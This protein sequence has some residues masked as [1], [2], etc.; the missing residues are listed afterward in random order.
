MTLMVLTFV[1]NKE[2]DLNVCRTES[3]SSVAR[4]LH[5]RL[6]ASL[7]QPYMHV[8]YNHNATVVTIICRI[9]AERMDQMIHISVK[10]D[11]DIF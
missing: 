8:Y 5:P 7:L 3:K 10:S 1:A 6:S 2:L 11:L 4:V 9:H